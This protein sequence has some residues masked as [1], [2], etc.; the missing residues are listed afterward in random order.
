MFKELSQKI[1]GQNFRQNGGE[2][3]YKSPIY[4]IFIKESGYANII[5]SSRSLLHEHLSKLYRNESWATWK[6]R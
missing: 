5:L 1:Y 3:V 6:Y 4:K 2:L